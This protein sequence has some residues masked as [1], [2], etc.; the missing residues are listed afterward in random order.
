VSRLSRQCRILNISQPYR[1][2]A[3]V[4]GIALLLREQLN[5]TGAQNPDLEPTKDAS[6]YEHLSNTMHRESKED[7][8]VQIRRKQ[9]HTNTHTL[10]LFLSL[11][12]TNLGAFKLLS[13]P[14]L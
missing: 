13:V 7:T 1:P 6:L 10:S 8:E 4:T 5:D 2:P 11:C 3:P 14:K 9:T 12:L